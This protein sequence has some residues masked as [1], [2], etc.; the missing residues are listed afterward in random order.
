MGV[1]VAA[2]MISGPQRPRAA[3]MATV[4]V[5]SVDLDRKLNSVVGTCGTM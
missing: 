1:R 4:R 5:C 2:M 3:A